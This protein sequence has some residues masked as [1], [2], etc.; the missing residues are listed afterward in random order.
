MPSIRKIIN[1][2][3]DSDADLMKLSK[4]MGTQVDQIVFKQYLDTSK[5]YSILNMGTPIIGG[6]HW[7]AVSNK[8]KL[9]FDPFGLPPPL[10]IPRNYREYE[11][12]VQ[13]IRFGHRGDYCVAWLYYLQHRNLGEFRQLFEELPELIFKKRNA[14]IRI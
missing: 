8:H 14:F 3:R 4:A 6:T 12:R 11:G 2:T 7:V 9:Y 10:V 5:D 13:D 1:S